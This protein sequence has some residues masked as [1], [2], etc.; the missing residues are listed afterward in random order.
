MTFPSLRLAR[1]WLVLG[2]ALWAFGV[3][4]AAEVTPLSDGW[5]FVR[6]DVP[7]AEAATFDDSGWATVSTPHTYNAADS[8]IGGARARGEPEGAY[9]R[10][11]AWYRLSLDH[12]P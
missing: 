7:G 3:A 11:P 5:R 2:L 12:Q 8:G 6:A 10:G 4:R 9:Y 1:P